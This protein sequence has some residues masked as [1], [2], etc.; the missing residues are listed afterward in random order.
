MEKIEFQRQ[1]TLS[2]FSYHFLCGNLW[3]SANALG[4]SSL[5]LNLFKCQHKCSV[6]FVSFSCLAET[7][8]FS[9][10]Y[11]SNNQRTTLTLCCKFCFV[12]ERLFSLYQARRPILG[13]VSLLFQAD[14]S[15]GFDYKVFSYS[16]DFR[17]TSQSEQVGPSII[18]LLFHLHN[19]RGIKLFIYFTQNGHGHWQF[20]QFN[21]F[22]FFR[23]IKK[24]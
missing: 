14:A 24:Y 11:I 1:K 7:K 10:Y 18:M 16:C 2:R 23:S 6:S 9:C 12:Q 21:Y 4:K 19:S 5:P 20:C 3:Q 8:L 22:E 15:L 17:G 13:H